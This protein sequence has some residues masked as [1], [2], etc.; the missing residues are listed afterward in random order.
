MGFIA[1]RNPKR[2]LCLYDQL[3]EDSVFKTDMNPFQSDDIR[4]SQSAGII[5]KEKHIEDS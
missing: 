5:S 3:D 4:D 2:V 1:Q